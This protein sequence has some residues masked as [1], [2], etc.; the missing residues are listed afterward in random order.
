MLEDIKAALNSRGVL[1]LSEDLEIL[2]SSYIKP[3]LWICYMGNEVYNVVCRDYS[4]F[5]SWEDVKK[6]LRKAKL[7]A[8]L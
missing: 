3:Y 5:M 1:S 4:R 8:L 7:E 6:L 2:P